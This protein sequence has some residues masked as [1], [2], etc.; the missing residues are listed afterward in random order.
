MPQ[1]PPAMMNHYT[2]GTPSRRAQSFPLNLADKI[3]PDVQKK[4]LLWLNR[5]Y[6]WPQVQER[7][8]FER[9]WDKILEMAR[10][11]IPYDDVFANDRHADSKAKNKADQSNREDNRVSDSVVHDAIQRLTDITYFIAF[12]EGLPCQFAIPDYIKQPNSTSEYRPL[13][14]R[15]AAGNALLQWNSGNMDVKR[16]SN[17]AYR[18]HYTYGCSFVMSDF[19]FRVEMINR[20]SNTGAIIPQPEITE[21]GTT[22]EPISIRKIWFNWRLPVYDMDNQPCPFF[23]EEVPRFA[24]LQ[25]VYDPV[26][27]PFGYVNLDTLQKGQ[28]IYSEP[29]MDSV[30]K[31][32]AISIGIGGKG[33][34][35]TAVAQI[36][37]PEFSVEAKWTL[38]PVMPF[39]PATGEFEMRADGKTPVPYQRFVMETFGPNIH[40]G[41]Q[42][43][44]RLQENYYPKRRLP[45]YASCHMPDLD[46]GAY[47]PSIGQLLYNHYVEL[48]LGME[49]FLD[50]KDQ[51]NEPP[52]WI[53]SSSPARNMN[54]NAKNAKIPVNGPNDF[55]WKQVPDGSQSVVQMMQ[56]IREQAQTTS[57]SVDA[58]M[59]KAMGSRTSATEAQNAFQSSMSAITTDID[60]LSSDLHGGYA[61][62]VWD[63]TG[64]WFDPD[65][66]QCITGSFGFAIQPEDMWINIGVVTN[67]GST[68]VEK[69]VKNQN[70]RYL[71]ETSA[72]DPAMAP[73]RPK[74]WKELLE[75]MGF[76][77]DIIEDGD[78]E[79]Q[80]QF[81]NMQACE[82]YLGY[83]VL[84]D[85]DQDH[86]IAIMV[87]TAYIK[88]Q[89]S[90]WNTT[91][92]YAANAP[93]LIQQIQQHQL[94]LQLQMQ[95][96]LAQQQMQVTQAQLGVHNDN[97]PQMKPVP[98]QPQPTQPTP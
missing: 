39:D 29:E 50:N 24:I 61:N 20:Q 48:C 1:V 54:L 17:I 75:F 55:G 83:P 73:S 16:N 70:V 88:D 42:V 49:Q 37:Q 94:I 85:P 34:S 69:I 52:A 81:A 46:S 66:L 74:L 79:Q 51:M 2:D 26:A 36:L 90:I 53:Q 67:V 87:L 89:R 3:T 4:M 97:P 68:Y 10:I 95:M 35:A 8:P 76:D 33:M 86:Q 5:N 98:Q 57:K 93:K 38:F 80:I 45:I 28:Y 32:L 9:M 25:K 56:M 78:R 96:Q 18:H 65:L 41:S 7:V 12:K 14:D 43:I 11:N 27:N 21:I 13:D 62:R 60:M 31:A 63:Y 64:M 71:L 44:L 23:F 84:V 91:P 19:R 77:P 92:E 22:F 59:G 15:I 47:A 6:I 40:S 58:I 82:T 30:R 72:M